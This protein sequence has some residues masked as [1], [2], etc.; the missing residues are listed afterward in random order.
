MTKQKEIDILAEAATRLGP[1][2]YAGTWLREQLPF[3]EQDMRADFPVGTIAMSL[4]EA[5][6]YVVGAQQ[7]A[8]KMIRDAQVNV[9]RMLEEAR[10]HAWEVREQTL[11]QLAKKLRE[12][13]SRAEAG[14]F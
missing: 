11:A 3:I 8:D 2:S 5:K 10:D 14:M 7:T 9:E 6:A 1:D 4:A 12:M 13:A